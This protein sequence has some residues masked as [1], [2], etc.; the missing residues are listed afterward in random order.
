[1]V[2][3]NLSGGVLT[4]N[5]S[6][7]SDAITVTKHGHTLTVSANGQTVGTFDTKDVDT[8][9]VDGG[10]GDD[11]IFIAPN[12]KQ[13]AILTGGPGNDILMGG[14]GRSI[15]IGGGGRDVLTGGS[16]SDLLIGG[17]Y[18]GTDADLT[19]LFGVWTGSK[20]YAQRVASAS[21]QLAGKVTADGEAD[22]LLGL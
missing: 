2:S 7:D 11:V 1:V 8:L 4:V 6:L 3:A 12:V 10:R 9:R 20:S 16:D 17:D 14:S 5:G 22:I 19:A 13:D 15:L 18:T 21:T